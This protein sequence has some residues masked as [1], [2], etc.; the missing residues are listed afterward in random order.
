MSRKVGENQV[1][2][3]RMVPVKHDVDVFVAGGGPAGMAAAVTAARQGVRVFLAEGQACFGGMGTAAGLPMFCAPTDGVHITSAGFGTEVYER[4]MAAEGV[5]P[6][7][8]SKPLTEIE[9]LFYNPE[10]L[11]R[12][13]DDLAEE[14]GMTFSLCTQFLDVEVEAGHVR[15]AICAAKSGLFAVTARIFVDGTGDG[16]LSARAGAPFEK[17]D[18][19]G[20]LQPP[21]LLSLWCDV[22]WNQARSAGHGV[23]QQEKVLRRALQEQTGILSTPDPHLPGMLPIG[24]HAAWGNIGHLFGTDGTDETSVTRALIRGRRLV[25]E[26]ERFYRQYV[27]GFERIQLVGTGSVLGVRETRRILGDYVLGLEDFKRRA[28]FPDEIGRF[29]YPVDLHA[30]RPD[31]E[32]FRRFEHEFRTLRYRPGEN[33]GIPY[34]CLTPRQ[35]ENVLV[36][37]RCLSSDRY[38]H[39]SVR[40]MPGCFITGQAAGM[41]AALA[42][43]GNGRTRDVPVPELQRKLVAMGAYLPHATASAAE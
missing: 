8:R 4:L 28:V 39:G 14:S 20:D 10:A 38:V 12:V 15:R 24:P 19:H 42:A 26:Y 30:T 18:E 11:K 9:P 22:D 21:T 33:Y 31:P 43:T 6:E 32:V 16:D 17:G 23:W 37:G 25:L 2:F 13:Y 36:A 41:A 5:L 7:L 1:R 40:V 34:R 29:S 35:L 3:S 27:K